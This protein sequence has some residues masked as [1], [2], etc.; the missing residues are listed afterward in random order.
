VCLRAYV[1]L[2]ACKNQA[3]FI[4][5]HGCLCQAVRVGDL[6]QFNAALAAHEAAFKRD[7]TYSLVLRLRQNVIKAGL[8]K[9]WLS[10]SRISFADISVK[11][12][13]ESPEDA[14]FLCAKVCLCPGPLHV[15][16]HATLLCFLHSHFA[17][18]ACLCLRWPSSLARIVPACMFACCVKC[19]DEALLVQCSS[20]GRLRG[21]MRQAIRD[22]VLDASLNHEEGYLCGLETTDVYSTTEPQAA[23]DRRI[24]FSLEVHNEAVKVCGTGCV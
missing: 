17:S 24:K 1:C 23:F 13:L 8:R 21:L 19:W 11:L 2:C 22:G 18:T 7:L 10:Y 20:S 14:E 6:A 3:R 15:L 9:I 4:I 16:Q 12:H 5:P